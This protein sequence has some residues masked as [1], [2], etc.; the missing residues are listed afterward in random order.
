MFIFDNEKTSKFLNLKYVNFLSDDSYLGILPSHAP[1]LS[2]IKKGK[3]FFRDEKNNQNSILLEKD[4]IL[5]IQNNK[6][7]IFLI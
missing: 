7:S 3:I 2:Y 1:M 6:I 5:E 4:G